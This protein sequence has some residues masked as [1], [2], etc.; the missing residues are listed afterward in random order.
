MAAASSKLIAISQN[1]TIVLIGAMQMYG[2]IWIPH[3][4]VCSSA[5]T[6]VTIFPVEDTALDF[7][8]NLKDF[9]YIIQEIAFLIFIPKKFA[10]KK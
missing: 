10:L 7:C 4:I 2:A 3:S 1:A 6:I 5:D 9:L 8:D